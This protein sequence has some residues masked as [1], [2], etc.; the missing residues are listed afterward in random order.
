MTLQEVLQAG[1]KFSTPALVLAGKGYFN[2]NEFKNAGLLTEAA[3]LSTEFIHE[4]VVLTVDEAK[5]VAAWN[6]ARAGT[7]TIGEASV[8]P[9]FKRF[10]AALKAG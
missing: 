4:P 2:F 5:L 9:L 3:I 7:Q 6:T 10:V 1:K 8:S